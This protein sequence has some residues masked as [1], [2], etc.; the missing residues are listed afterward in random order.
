MRV[1]HE[2]RHLVC[3]RSLCWA[4]LLCSVPGVAPFYLPGVLPTDYSTGEEIRIKVNSLTS[5]STHIPYPYYGLNV[6]TPDNRVHIAEN[7]GEMLFGDEIESTSYEV[8]MGVETNCTDL[9]TTT[10]T[11]EE[12]DLFIERVDGNYMVN[13]IVDNLPAASRVPLVGGESFI[14]YEY[15]YALGFKS[16]ELGHA[17]WDNVDDVRV[18]AYYVNNHLDITI[19]YHEVQE[20]DCGDTVWLDLESAMGYERVAVARGRKAGAKAACLRRVVGIVVEASSRDYGRPEE[21]ATALRRCD[22]F[23]ALQLEPT[24][25]TIQWTYDVHFEKS[26]VRWA[27]RWDIYMSMDNRYSDSVHWMSVLHS[28]L[29]AIALGTT[30]A[31]IFVRTLR[32][33]LL[34][35]N[36]V[37]PLLDVVNIT[38]ETGWKRV[39]KDIFRGP[40]HHPLCFAA[41]VG[42][43]SQLAAVVFAAI[44][45]GALGFLSPA[46]RGSLMLAFLIFFVLL[47]YLA[48]YRAA[49]LY[50]L[51]G[52]TRWQRCAMTTAFAYPGLVF[53]LFFVVN[54][55]LWSKGSTAALPFRNMICVLTLWYCVSAPLTFLGCRAGF[56]H[57]RDKLSCPPSVVPSRVPA[58]GW[59]WHPLLQSLVC[60]WV[61]FCVIFVELYMIMGSLWLDQF[62]YVYGFSFLAFL[63]A[64]LCCVE[65]TLI[66]IYLQLNRGDYRWYWSSFCTSGSVALWIWGYSWY[67]F[68][69]KLEM[70]STLSAFLYIA[71]MFLISLSLFMV[72]GVVGFVATSVFVK[73]LFGS[74]KLD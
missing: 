18:R 25:G 14:F 72:F 50:N 43:S 11:E 65:V 26:P 2:R 12:V 4:C 1:S 51:Y 24:M 44:V 34:R 21:N 37:P 36:T 10:L 5:V 31:F 28:M 54:L 23:G 20:G 38:E 55:G 60:G 46:N 48:G 15:G 69:T 52:G 42:T 73:V 61:P 17:P 9:C 29:L 62:Y 3:L 59:L 63:L 32:Q 53:G 66:K 45:L 40:S 41:L 13:W 74:V 39:H 49:R 6:C 22:S 71:Y 47:S 68:S 67:F 8:K 35:Y 27:S 30:V 70:V 19:Q 33:D 56:L 7:L 64:C 58:Q 57:P 16:Y